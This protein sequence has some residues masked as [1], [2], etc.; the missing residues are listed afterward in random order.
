MLETPVL[1]PVYVS[2]L[3]AG[4]VNTTRVGTGCLLFNEVHAC[5]TVGWV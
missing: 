5:V 2:L 4:N 3:E 1:K